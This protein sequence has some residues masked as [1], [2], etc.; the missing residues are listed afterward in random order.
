MSIK[1]RVIATLI[2][3]SFFSTPVYSSNQELLTAKALFCTTGP[4]VSTQWEA[5]K[6]VTDFSRFE[7]SFTFSEINVNQGTARLIGVSGSS[8][9]K[10]LVTPIGVTFIEITGIG[11]VFITTIYNKKL[12]GT[13]KF[14]IVDTRHNSVIDPIPSQYYGTCE[15]TP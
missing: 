11:G 6:P 1:V 4:G 7:T 10:A 15:I 2:L 5:G 12:E 13:V 14:P 8:T 3:I 9:V